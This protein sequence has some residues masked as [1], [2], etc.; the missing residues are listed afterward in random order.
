MA[1]K[2]KQLT[3]LGLFNAYFD[4]RCNKRNTINAL[5]FE[6]EL[7]KNL[8]ELYRNLKDSSYT[9]GRSVCFVITKPKPRE[10]WAADFRDRIV[11]HL[12]YNAIKD[13]FYNRFI[14][15]SFSCIPE[16]GT[17]AACR[18]LQHFILE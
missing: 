3:F 18:R 4:C 13:R 17:L 2:L 6:F 8:L 12:V 9:I 7:E 16:K 15:E 11:H 14:Y 10:I 5:A 1:D